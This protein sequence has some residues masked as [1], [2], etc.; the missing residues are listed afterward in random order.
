MILDLKYM[1]CNKLRSTNY[2][3]GSRGITLTETVVYVALLGAMV[4]LVAN[5]LIQVVNVYNRVRAEREVLSNARLVLETVNKNISYAVEVYDPTSRFNIDLGQLSL[6][7]AN[8]PTVEHI[9]NYVDFWVDNGGFWVKKEGSSSSLISASSVRVTQFRLERILQ[10]LA[11]ES[12]RITLRLEHV[13]SAF[14][15]S[16]VLTSTTAFRGNY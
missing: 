15:S 10:G 14:S 3:L 16:I 7:T 9:V 6:V 4:V 12:V 5:F 2:G 11:R 13:N 1:H 8:E